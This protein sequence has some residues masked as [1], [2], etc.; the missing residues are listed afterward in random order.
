MSDMSR[1]C[2]RDPERP[3]I[4]KPFAVEHDGKTWCCA[5]DGV[6]LLAR[7]DLPAEVVPDAPR[8]DKI[9]LA[10]TGPGKPSTVVHLRAGFGSPLWGDPCPCCGQTV[11]CLWPAPERLV[12]FRG[13]VVNAVLAARILDCVPDGDGLCEVGKS[14]EDEDEDEG[15]L[16]MRGETWIALL[17]PFRAEQ[18]GLSEVAP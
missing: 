11:G 12:I 16:W 2:S 3:T 1:L 13:R 4:A 9:L 5:T 14:G 8:V 18:D 15:S 7:C 17:M 6:C 10:A